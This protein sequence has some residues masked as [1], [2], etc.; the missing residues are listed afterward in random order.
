MA[1]TGSEPGRAAQRRRTRKAIVAAAA[2]LLARGRTPSVTEVAEAAE[3]SRRTVYMYFPTLEQLLVD[4]S[5]L[6]ITRETVD[7]ALD[8]AEASDDVEARVEAMARAVQRLFVSTEQ[9]GRTLLRLTVDSGTGNRSPDQPLR[10]YRRVEWIERA[11][12]PLRGKLDA[13][14]FKRLVSALAL[15]IGWEALIV[16]RDIRALSLKEAEDVS[17][18]AARALV[19]AT[20]EE[21]GLAAPRAARASPARR[22]PQRK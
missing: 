1:D 15:V 13:P 8:A 14:R 9:Q 7:A 22:A 10:G 20:L 6:S 19:R 5:L 2:E 21:A 11:L 12:A 4:A 17:A 18:W 16:E 3:V